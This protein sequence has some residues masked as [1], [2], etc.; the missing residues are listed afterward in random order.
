[1]FDRELRFRRINER[2]AAI[3]GR[4]V[5]EH[6]GR[7]VHEILPVIAQDVEALARQVFETGKPLVDIPPSGETVDQPGVV[8]HF[9]EQSYPLFDSTGTVTG[10]NVV[11]E[12]VTGR[13]RAEAALRESEAR[14]RAIVQQ[15]KRVSA[16]CSASSTRC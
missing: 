3:N 4:P 12:E 1:M 15:C 9:L 2:L 5:A 11:V 16:T 10:I 13:I 7:T 8:R 14:F 6:I